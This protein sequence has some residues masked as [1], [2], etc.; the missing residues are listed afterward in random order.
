MEGEGIKK[1]ISSMPGIYHFSVDN[2]LKDISEA[3]GIK[4][5][6]LFGIPKAKDEKGSLSYKEDGIVQKAIKTI[7]KN[8]KDLIVITDVCLCGWTTHGHCGIIKRKKIS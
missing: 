2:L 6:L 1:E 8:F 3:A 7:K 4:S 5:I